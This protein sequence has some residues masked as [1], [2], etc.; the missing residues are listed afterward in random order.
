MKNESGVDSSVCIMVWIS[1]IPEVLF[2][3]SYPHEHELVPWIRDRGSIKRLTLVDLTTPNERQSFSLTDPLDIS[4]PT[5]VRIIRFPIEDHQTPPCIREFNSFL[6]MLK[7][8]IMSKNIS[9]AHP[10]I[11]HCKGGHGRSPMVAAALMSIL[12][13]EPVSDWIN[14]ITQLHH[15]TP[16]IHPKY[17]RRLCPVSSIQQEFLINHFDSI[18]RH[19]THNPPNTHHSI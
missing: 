8:E 9:E 3:G 6:Q 4:L 7:S 16:G 14:R 15:A 11:I 13:Q 1:I 19:P 18:Y 5:I 2:F 12:H 10:M 17:L